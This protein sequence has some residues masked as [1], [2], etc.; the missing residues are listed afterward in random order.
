MRRYTGL[1]VWLHGFSAAVI[2]GA[3]TALGTLPAVH[4]DKAGIEMLKSAALSGAF[5]GVIAYLKQSPVPGKTSAT[6]GQT[7]LQ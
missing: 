7:P 4:F 2:G 1:R 3:V 5:V 6:T